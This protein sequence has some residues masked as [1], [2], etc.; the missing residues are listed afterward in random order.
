MAWCTLGHFF[1]SVDWRSG[2]C[3]C[4]GFRRSWYVIRLLQRWLKERVENWPHSFSLNCAI[5]SSLS[6]LSTLF[7]MALIDHW[8]ITDL[9]VHVHLKHSVSPIW[10]L[11][12][13][14]HSFF[15][16][17]SHPQLLRISTPNAVF[18]SNTANPASTVAVKSRI[19]SRNFA[20]SRIPKCIS[21][22]SRI[23]AISFQTLSKDSELKRVL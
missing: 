19:T 6:T 14:S 12:Q 23:P 11:I 2:S 3:C 10:V 5:I 8:S 13:H 9:V 15:K 1:F 22:K 20:F 21:I 7:A 18:F 4:F 17:I 16:T